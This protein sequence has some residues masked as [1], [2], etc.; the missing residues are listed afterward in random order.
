[1]TT[2]L[3]EIQVDKLA[4]DTFTVVE[5]TLPDLENGQVLFQVDQFAVTAN[6]VTYAVFGD[7]MNY[8]K[9]FPT[10]QPT[11][12]SGNPEL[13]SAH[14]SCGVVPVWGFGNVVASRCNGVE[15]GARYYGYFPMASHVVVEPAKVTAAGFFDGA[16]H[17]RELHSV[18]NSYLRTTEDSGYVAEREAE[19]M[20]LRPL[21]T[22]SFL[23][24]DFLADNA[25]F[26]AHTVVLSSAS[27]K[28]TYGA[29]FCLSQRGL[30]KV[31][32][33]TSERNRAFTE[34]LGCYDRVLTYDEINRLDREPTVYVD[35]AGSATVRFDMHTYL[36]DDLRYS[37]AVGG[38]HWDDRTASAPLPGPS[39]QL[40]FAPAQVSKRN[41]DW[42][43]AE[44]QHRLAHQW[45]QFLTTVTAGSHPWMTIENVV[46]AQAT[47]EC[48]RAQATGDALPEIGYIASVV[49][50]PIE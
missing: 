38:T 29:A 18:Y 13:V 41:A 22:T 46:G 24:D 6:N 45:T 27:S 15:V 21:F 49:A 30:V 11:T 17:R 48:F 26:G 44:F 31:V 42:G 2:A 20:L 35:L 19:Q 32:G 28:T 12:A 8:W 9:F 39:P 5:A 50:A 10:H 33:L 14:T 36:G 3:T 4:I 34:R 40:F 47:G 37:C 43:P 1:M 16:A 7:A 23:I 25:M